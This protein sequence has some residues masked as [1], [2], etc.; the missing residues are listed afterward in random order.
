M[1]EV[2]FQVG[3]S[4]TYWS[5]PPE[6][7]AKIDDHLI[8][9]YP[10]LGERTVD[11]KGKLEE[12]PHQLTIELLNKS[13]KQTV[14]ENNKIIKDQLIHIKYLYLD[15]IDIGEMLWTKSIY[16]PKPEQTDPDRPTEMKNCIDLG[17]NGKWVFAFSVPT[18]I[19]LLENI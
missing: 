1:E 13:N 15:Q 7:R 14:V 12:G 19:W 10:L 4:S 17:Y 11:W 6:V 5:K 9:D 8:L 16:Y 3:L 18:Y 2:E